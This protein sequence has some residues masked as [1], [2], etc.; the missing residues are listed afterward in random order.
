[1][2][3]QLK[4]WQRNRILEKEAI[5]EAIWQKLILMRC[6]KGLNFE[7]LSRLRD[8]ATL[9][10]H[11]K[12]FYGAHDLV[13]TDEMRVAVALQA[14]LLILN[15]D[16]D[17]YRDWN[18]IIVYPGEF[19]LDYE[20]ED[21]FGVVHHVREIAV[22]EAWSS[23]P[24]ILSWQDA[25]GTALQPGYNVV[26]HEFAHKIDMLYEGANGCPQLHAMMSG[27]TWHEV[28]SQ[29]YVKFCSQ[30]ERQQETVID[31]YAAESPAEFFA[32]LSEA[33]FELPQIVQQHFP[34][35]YEQL[36]LFYRQDPAQ[37]H[38]SVFDV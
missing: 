24:V 2:G 19:I 33:F 34:P 37:R 4:D 13:I 20:Y 29:A 22:G 11:Q 14:C 38:R 16:L 21:E 31:P 8:C 25:A 36:A 30:V 17:Y 23:G 1:M 9:F 35:V 12:Q 10:L 6:L 15:L 28:F 5:P 7:E 26:I 32:V 3:W 18:L 27:Y